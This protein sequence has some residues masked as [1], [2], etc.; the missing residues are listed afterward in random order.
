[1]PRLPGLMKTIAGGERPL[2]HISFF[3]RTSHVS[4]PV[5]ALIDTGSSSTVLSPSDILSSRMP[6]SKMQSGPSVRLGGLT[7]FNHSLGPA[8]MTFKTEKNEPFKADLPNIG[9][10]V[11]TK[12]DQKTR[13]EVKL[14]P[15][16]IG[17]DFLEHQRLALYYNPSAKIIYLESVSVVKDTE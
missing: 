13:D 2:P 6:I 10:L 3:L 14:Y 12:L 9:A 1:M 8:S 15:S 5:V 11:P 4:K 16:I 17:M 7:F